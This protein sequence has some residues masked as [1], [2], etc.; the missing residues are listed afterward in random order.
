MA[1]GQA[2]S[3]TGKV[4]SREIFGSTGDL[5]G[6]GGDARSIFSS[7]DEAL[8]KQSLRL[9][10]KGLERER[11][12][13]L[14]FKTDLTPAQNRKLA[15]LQ[16]QI[17]K[18]E[19]KAGEESG[20]TIEELE[21][22]AALYKESYAILGKDYV[23]KESNTQ[24]QALAEEVDALLAP[25][26][27]GGKKARLETLQKLEVSAL[28]A[29]VDSPESTTNRLRL[30]NIKRQIAELT[31]PRQL[32]RLSPA[33]RQQYD[34]LV[35]RINDVAKTEFL[36]PSRKKIRIEQITSSLSQLRAQEA[37]FGEDVAR[38]TTAQVARSYRR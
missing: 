12:N 6:G 9:S 34:D 37:A 32:N 26:L 4:V 16:K 20:L 24:L 17:T 15:E 5:F 11:N 19:G 38:P 3:N 31:A 8:A 33:E 14:G 36:P 2:N 10:I 23:D 22:R 28:D 13:L 25:K 29:L 27:R 1:I 7:G 35:E 21:E 18:I 30:R